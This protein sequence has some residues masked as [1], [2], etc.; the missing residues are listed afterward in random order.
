MNS[1][2]DFMLNCKDKTHCHNKMPKCPGNNGLSENYCHRKKG[3]IGNHA[4]PF[5]VW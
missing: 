1:I 2:E 5:N 3:H 4:G